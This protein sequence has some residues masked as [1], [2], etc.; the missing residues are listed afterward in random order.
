MIFLKLAVK[1]LKNRKFTASLTVLSIALSLALLL[2]VERAKRA[3]EE[4]FSQSVSQVDLLVGARTGPI[5]LILYTVFN[6]GSASNNISW[7]SYQDIKLNPKVEWTIPYSLG[8]GHQ[9]FRVVGTDENFYQ[10]YRFRG[11]ESI[12]FESGQPALGIWDVVIG[13]EVQKKLKYK[14]SDKVVIAH[15]VTRGKAIQ[16]HDDKP[17]HI[18][19]ILKP[20]GTAVDQSLYISLQGMEALHLDWG[21]TVDDQSK[22][23]NES[24]TKENIQIDQIT[25]FFVRTK[26]RIQTLGLQREI[27][28][29]TEEP[30][31][32]IIPG[33]TLASLW[34]GL[35]Q[36]EVV[37][38][39]ISYMVMAVGFASMLSSILA[40][41]NERR[42]EMSILR[43]IGASPSKIIL[44]LVLESLFLTSL[45]IIFGLIIELS[46]FFILAN[47]LANQFGF[48]VVGNAITK[49]EIIY[50]VITFV[51][52]SLIGLIPA[53]IA[54]RT[55][56]KDGLSVR[57]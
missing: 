54:T 48:Y 52:G 8:D 43:S 44:L 45:G 37:L 26:S 36:I 38:K 53:F 2:S 35:S 7:K 14:L 33:A 29:Y 22:K 5:N 57:I 12:Q 30:L 27:N 19:G 47:W 50:M 17:F 49:I 28:E 1:S 15:G 39:I 6:M 16:M 42:R 10:H 34:Q 24:L 9:G 31:L 51:L 21:T 56:L 40:G 55:A 4:G 46:G 20:T 11:Q 25:S 18:T 23:S 32:S 3:S 13:S 41:L